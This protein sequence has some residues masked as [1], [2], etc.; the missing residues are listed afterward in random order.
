MANHKSDPTFV[1]IE[2]EVYQLN[3]VRADLISDIVEFILDNGASY[4]TIGILKIAIL[5]Y[6]ILFYKISCDF[7]VDFNLIKHILIKTNSNY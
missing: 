2:K 4:I 6:L 3:E 5:K 7:R 1:Y